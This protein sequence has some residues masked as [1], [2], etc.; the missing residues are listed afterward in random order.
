MRP[1]LANFDATGHYEAGTYTSDD[2]L[3]PGQYRLSAHCWKVGPNMS[4][5]PTVSYI[6]HKYQKAGTS[7]LEELTVAANGGPVVRNIDLDGR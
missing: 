2:G 3:I 7:D 6:S 4:N 1:G 5:I